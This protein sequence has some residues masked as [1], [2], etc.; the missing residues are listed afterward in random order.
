MSAPILAAV[1]A[2]LCF[3]SKSADGQS[4]YRGNPQHTG[5]YIGP[6]PGI[7]PSITWKFKT[8]AKIFS[9]PVIDKAT[10]FI[11]SDDSCFYALDKSTGNLRWKFKTGGRVSSSAAVQNDVVYINSFD[12]YVYALNAKSGK[13]VWKFNTGGEKVFQALNL[14]GVNTDGKI[15]EDPWDMYLASP[16]VGKGKV[17]IGNGNGTFF[18]LDATNGQLAWQFKTGGVI[19][20]SPTVSGD[21]VYFASWDSYIY[22]VNSNNGKE[23]WRFKTGID[24][25]YHNQV[26]F[27]SSPAISGNVLYIGCRDANMRAIDRFTGKLLWAFSTQGSWIIGAPAIHNNRVYFGT[28]DTYRILSLDAKTG[29]IIFDRPAKSYIFS[30]PAIAGNK[31]YVGTFAGFLYEMDCTSGKPRSVFRTDA[32]AENGKVYLN[33]DS[34]F[35]NT[36]VFPD[37]TW[38]G[39]LQSMNYLYSMG[40]ILSSPAI[41]EGKIYFGSTDGFVYAL[42]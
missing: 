18:A 31:L 4:C 16:V 7:S 19:H 1:L 39:M 29:A 6:G 42:E 35:N 8:H 3:T 22:A 28:S 25:V 20:S 23:F 21:S 2:I 30:S 36:K 37:P 17:F 9:S 11:G 40:S 12:G 41:S 27:Q 38:N 5:C 15:V 24:T 32:S 33:A 34:T 10:L 14:H 26:G 13:L